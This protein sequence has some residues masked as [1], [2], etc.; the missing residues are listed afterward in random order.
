MEFFTSERLY[1]NIFYKEILALHIM[2]KAKKPTGKDEKKPP[3]KNSLMDVI[4][5]TVQPPPRA[6]TPPEESPQKK[7]RK[8]SD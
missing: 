7:G 5:Q 2:A 3:R 8:K 4:K 1:K 6:I